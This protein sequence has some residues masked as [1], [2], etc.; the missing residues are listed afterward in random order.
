MKLDPDPSREPRPATAAKRERP[1]G[2]RAQIEADARAGKLPEPS[3]FGA[4]TR[5]RFRTKL[6]AVLALAMAG[7]A[8]DSL[9]SRSIPSARAPRQSPLPQSLHHGA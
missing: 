5:K 1:P 4:A 3:D 2:R 8:T 6:A 7:I 9:P